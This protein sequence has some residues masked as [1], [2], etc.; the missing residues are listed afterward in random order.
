VILY[1]NGDSHSAGAEIVNNHCFAKDDPLYWALDRKPHPDNL[2]LSYGCLIANQLGSILECDA[3]SAASNDRILRTTQEYLQTKT[4]NLIII[5]WSTW[6]REEWVLDNTYY[7]VT[8]SG[9][10]HVPKELQQRYKE[11][12]IGQTHQIRELKLLNWH[13]RIWQLHQELNSKNIPHIFFN[14]YSD[15]SSIRS[16]QITTDTIQIIPNE[17]DWGS[18]YV[19]PYDSDI[20]Y[21]NWCKQKGFETVN[22]NSYHFGAD[23]HRAWAE[24]LLENYIQKTLTNKS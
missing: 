7:Q 1:V 11:W 5:G 23:A 12:V 13:N 6:E 14:T 19:A 22:P 4:P 10:D 24:Y 2:K 15:F 16:R 3:E 20:T 8:A 18:N 17:Y 21:Y 9:T